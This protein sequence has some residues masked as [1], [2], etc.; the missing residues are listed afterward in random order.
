MKIPYNKL[1][2]SGNETVYIKDALKRGQISGDGYYTDLVTSF[3]EKRFCVGRAMMTTSATHALEL[4]CLAIDLQQGDEVIM[5]SFTFPST[6]NAVMLRGGR[7]VFAEI[8]EETLNIDPLDVEKRISSKT[9][10]I[11]AVHYAGIGCEMD[12]I[13]DLADRYG[14]YVIEDAAQAVN[15]RYKGKYLGSWGDM[16]CYSFHGT[17]NYT[18]GEGGAILI[19]GTDSFLN[20]KIETIRQKGTNRTQ[21]LRGEVDRYCWVEVGSSYTPSDILMAF[22]Y[23]QLMDLDYITAAR[24]KIHDYYSTELQEYVKAGT[25]KTMTIPPDCEP[26][27]HLF[28]ILLP[29]EKLR[30][31]VM[32]GL[33]N[34]GISAAIHFVPLHSAPMGVRLGYKKE[35]LPV[36]ENVSSCLLRL[37]MYTGMIREE[38]E[39]VIENLKEILKVI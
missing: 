27:Y 35:E 21:F 38:M 10:A 25:L 23:S 17:K 14:L 4:S 30:D 6:A 2:C 34:R 5:P 19:N 39:Y 18:S 3:I 36:T 31:K 8:K 37:P 22:L 11:I 33:N 13:M 9:R 15:A 29:S 7:P 1:Y 28:Y 12:K 16:G 32:Y 24:K 26:N 20:G